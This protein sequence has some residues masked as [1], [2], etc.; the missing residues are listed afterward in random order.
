M[1][2]DID[3]TYMLRCNF[4]F[5]ASKVPHRYHII[6]QTFA[7]AGTTSMFEYEV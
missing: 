4:Y 3:H 2:Y 7:F 1:V 6:C 5:G